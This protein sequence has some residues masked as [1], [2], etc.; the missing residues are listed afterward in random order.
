MTL[1]FCPGCKC[2]FIREPCPGTSGSGGIMTSARSK[3]AKRAR[4]VR[5]RAKPL[6]VSGAQLLVFT[7]MLARGLLCEY[8]YRP[9]T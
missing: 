9:E 2:R 6:G 5:K 7:R 8:V 1:D 3:K 4:G